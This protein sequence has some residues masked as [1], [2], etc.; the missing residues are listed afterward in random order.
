MG[1]YYGAKD[2]TSWAVTS[3]PA[4]SLAIMS[5]IL[6]PSSRATCQEKL[7]LESTSTSSPFT[8]TTTP[9][10][11]CPRMVME[12]ASTTL[13]SAGSIMVR[14]KGSGVG[15]GLGSTVVAIGVG[16]GV[17]LGV[18]ASAAFGVDVGVGLGVPAGVVLG[19]KAVCG[20][21]VAVGLGE[22]PGL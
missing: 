10:S 18:P 13:P 20:V 7:P 9:W 3:L 14:N 5:M 11:V 19:V 15:V 17:G 21:G 4:S 16:T 2:T 22:V 12:L 1:R 6:E 8:L